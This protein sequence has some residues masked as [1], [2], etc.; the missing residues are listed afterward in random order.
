MI[1]KTI[2]R[3]LK[4]LISSKNNHRID[5]ILNYTLALIKSPISSLPL[6]I[7]IEPSAICNLRC[8]MCSLEKNTL[9]KKFLTPG[10]LSII[11]NKFNASSV[12]LTG[13]GET[14]L[15]PYF[16]KLLKVCFDKHIKTSFITNI[17]LLN[18]KHLK[19]I[20]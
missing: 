19:A 12:N 13:M 11:L 2:F 3:G 1:N 10:N 14:L 15:N 7:Q 5:T 8:K 4:N 6:E 17:Q 9:D 20:K 18:Q 16:E